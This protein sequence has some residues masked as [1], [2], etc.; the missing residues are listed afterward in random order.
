ML[1]QEDDM[2]I[3]ALARRGWSQS[4]I[5]RHTGRDRKTIRKYLAGNGPSR[6]QAPSCLEPYRAYLRSAVR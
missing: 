1:T 2:E 5:A 6:E 3:H 4:A